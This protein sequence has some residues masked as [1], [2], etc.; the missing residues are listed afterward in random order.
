M[1]FDPMERA[2]SKP[3]P[4]PTPEE[5]GKLPKTFMQ[6]ARR[7]PKLAAA[8]QSIGEHTATMGPLDKKTQHLIKIGICLGAG[9]ESAMR[10]H[11]RRAIQAGATEA[12]LEQ[13]VM[14]GMTT[15]GFPRTV[16][17]W[18]WV[19]Q[20]IERDTDDAKGSDAKDDGSGAG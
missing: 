19:L 4:P 2:L 6:F 12:E 7:F 11:T 16:A 17:A 3:T 18:Q 9:L 1:I 5:P 13:A 10:S 14:L 8:H 15:C 20:Q